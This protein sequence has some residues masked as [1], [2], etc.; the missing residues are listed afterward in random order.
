MLIQLLETVYVTP[1]L[2]TWKME[3]MMAL[4]VLINNVFLIV[5]L[6]IIP[7]SVMIVGLL[8]LLLE[9]ITQILKLQNQCFVKRVH[10]VVNVFAQQ[11]VPLDLMDME[12]V[13]LLV[14]REINRTMGL[15]ALI[16]VG[17]HQM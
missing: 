4:K 8:K 6:M 7:L 3:L 11:V 10:Q 15:E 2:F 5:M 12:D 14:I 13:F 9:L 16:N 17:L 1:L